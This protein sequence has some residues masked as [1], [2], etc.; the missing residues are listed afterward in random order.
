M[1]VWSWPVLLVLASL[2]AARGDEVAGTAAGGIGLSEIFLGFGAPKCRWSAEEWRTELEAL[3]DDLGVSRFTVAHVMR[4]Q[5]ADWDAPGDPCMGP[6]PFGPVYGKY[7]AFYPSNLTCAQVHHNCAPS[8]EAPAPGLRNM[9]EAAR[10]LGIKVNLGLSIINTAPKHFGGGHYPPNDEAWRIFGR[11]SVQ[12]LEELWGL[13]GADYSDVISGIYEPIEGGNCAPLMT[14]PIQAEFL[15]N[16][17]ARAKTLPRGEHL[18]TFKSPGFRGP[19]VYKAE[20]CKET[21]GG[22]EYGE[23]WSGV[24]RDAPDFA[25]IL[26]QDGRGLWN[27]PETVQEMMEGLEKAA[28]SNGRPFG[29]NVELFGPSDDPSIPPYPSVMCKNRLP[30]P[31][32]RVRAQLEQEGPCSDLLTAWEWNT[33]LHPEKG[34]CDEHYQELAAELLGNYTAYI[35]RV[36]NHHQ[37]TI[38]DTNDELERNSRR[39]VGGAPPPPQAPSAPDRG[40]LGGI[41]TGPAPRCTPRQAAG[42]EDQAL[43]RAKLAEGFHGVLTAGGYVPAGPGQQWRYLSLWPRNR[44]LVSCRRA[45]PGLV[46]RLRQEGG[47]WR[48]DYVSE[49]GGWGK[50]GGCTPCRTAGA[51]GPP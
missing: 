39:G 2:G 24:F 22:K 34:Y 50:W 45:W 35:G 5:D 17:S 23:Y 3:Q 41:V 18:V 16:V 26:P 1:K 14:N 43:R 33:C 29:M 15:Q 13:Y 51:R 46:P 28:R 21:L 25:Y 31:W 32:P 11:F 19:G 38:I 7:W 47:T 49:L 30:A 36:K 6:E 9:F 4:G 12:V 48:E 40:P 42:R 20:A 44:A 37:A 10:S 27:S 8:E